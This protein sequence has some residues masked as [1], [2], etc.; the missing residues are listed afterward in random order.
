METLDVTGLQGST[1]EYLEQLIVRL[2]QYEKSGKDTAPTVRDDIELRFTTQ[3][4]KT[5]GPVTRRE[6]YEDR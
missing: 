1:V 2:R 3:P 5:L 6:L 4:S